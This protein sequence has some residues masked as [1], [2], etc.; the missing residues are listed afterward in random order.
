MRKI[1]VVVVLGALSGLA[2][3]AVSQAKPGHAAA[4]SQCRHERAQ[5]GKKAFR[6]LFGKKHAMK[7]CVAK[8]LAQQQQNKQSAEQQCRAERDADAAA[9][10][11][12]YGTNHN[13][14][15]AFGKC[16]SQK[17]KALAEARQ[18]ATIN[19]AK[20]CE[21]EKSG[22][23]AAFR[24]KYGTNHNKRNAFGKCVSSKVNGK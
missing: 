23:A 4:V 12:K 22:D 20:Q 7:T 8:A 3:T 19:A 13:K 11:A 6:D 16:V 1:L 21:A 14:K 15:N 9:F 24:D 5:M 10:M 18:E 2:V 17:A